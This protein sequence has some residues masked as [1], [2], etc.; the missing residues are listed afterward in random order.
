M[1]LNWCGKACSL[2]PEYLKW[3]SIWLVTSFQCQHPCGRL[4]SKTTRRKS[5]W[6]RCRRLNV[7]CR[8]FRFGLM[9]VYS[10]VNFHSSPSLANSSLL[11]IGQTRVCFGISSFCASHGMGSQELDDVISSLKNGCSYD[12]YDGVSSVGDCYV[13]RN[14]DTHYDKNVAWSQNFCVVV[15]SLLLSSSE[16]SGHF[17][18]LLIMLNLFF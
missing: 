15:F 4:L 9:C 6:F 2:L 18:R 5:P 1:H 16:T 8:S 11:N 7:W 12:C 17:V 3:M 14:A 10:K 13:R